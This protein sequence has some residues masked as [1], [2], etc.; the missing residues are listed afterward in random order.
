M[1]HEQTLAQNAPLALL[2]LFFIAGIF[3]D[4]IL[5]IL[6]ISRRNEWPGVA[7]ELSEK[8]WSYADV[9]YL[10]IAA[11]LPM[12]I[13]HAFAYIAIALEIATA[14]DLESPLVILQTVLTHAAVLFVG[15]RLFRIKG[16]SGKEAFGVRPVG[17][18]RDAQ[19]GLMS[20]M[21]ILPLVAIGA[22]ATGFLMNKFH[23]EAPM[24]YPLKL[25][26]GNYSLTLKSCIVLAACITAPIVEELFF[27]G[28]AMPFIAK[29][30]GT[31]TAVI[32]VSLVFASIHMSLP[33]FLPIFLLS[34]G[35]C[36]AYIISGSLL[37]SIIMHSLFNTMTMLVVLTLKNP[38]HFLLK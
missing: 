22:V 35:L 13:I 30:T 38:E 12:S 20:Y 15:W 2:G 6:F 23:I 8:P 37:T 25:L 26:T 9:G 32:I 34:V 4:I 14:A 19:Y 1:D 5:I 16:I 31:L 7:A 21:A 24:Q 36:L 11:L 18:I 28:V 17:I 10:I 29:K 27:R 3:F 33:A